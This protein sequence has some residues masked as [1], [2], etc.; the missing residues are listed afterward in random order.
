MSSAPIA[1][2]SELRVLL[3]YLQ[4]VSDAVIAATAGL[5]DE[6]RRAGVPSG[7][8]LLGLIHHLTGVEQHWIQSVFLGDGRT[9]ARRCTRRKDVRPPT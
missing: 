3:G 8:N 4:R 9:T 1:D 2:P 5:G 6:V 7:T